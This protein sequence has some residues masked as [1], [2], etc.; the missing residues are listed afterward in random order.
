M[1]V[2]LTLIGISPAAVLVI[3][4]AIF[5]VWSVVRKREE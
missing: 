4:V 2:A 1:V 3:A 5:L